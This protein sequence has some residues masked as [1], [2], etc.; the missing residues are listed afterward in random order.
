[1]L[2]EARSKTDYQQRIRIYREIERLVLDDAPWISQHHSAFAYLY[3]P[4]VQGIEVNALGAHY[5]P[6]KKVWL[7]TPKDHRMSTR[8]K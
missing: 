8:E 1:L 3:Q 6:M 4:Y 5:I 2:E 7:E